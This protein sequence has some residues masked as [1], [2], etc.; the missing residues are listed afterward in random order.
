MLI[1]NGGIEGINGELF[2][3]K[4]SQLVKSNS[5]LDP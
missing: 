3:V 1:V 4:V 5:I 2:E